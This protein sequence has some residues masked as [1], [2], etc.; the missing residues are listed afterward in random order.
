MCAFEIFLKS[1]SRGRS[2][3]TQKIKPLREKTFLWHHFWCHRADLTFEGGIK[4]DATRLKPAFV[5]AFWR[6]NGAKPRR[7]L[8]SGAK[9]EPISRKISSH[10]PTAT[11]GPPKR[12][13]FWDFLKIL[14]ER[15]LCWQ[16]ETVLSS[17]FY[18]RT[19]TWR[20]KKRHGF[21]KKLSTKLPKPAP[22]KKRHLFFAFLLRWSAVADSGMVPAALP[23]TPV[24]HGF[25]AK[26]KHRADV[27][28]LLLYRNIQSKK[29]NTASKLFPSTT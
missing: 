3:E 21:S 24:P 28:L 6:Q 11:F 1:L 14:F 26:S 4:I 5:L 23:S 22:L 2:W 12:H 7:S 19:A 27:F 29:V 20:A 18:L 25:E 13:W 9:T 16:R 10:H 17:P 15:R 8:A